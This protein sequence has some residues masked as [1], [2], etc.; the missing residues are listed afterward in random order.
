MGNHQFDGQI[1]F[2]LYALIAM[3]VINIAAN[4]IAMYKDKKIYK[5]DVDRQLERMY[6]Y[7]VKPL[8]STTRDRTGG[9]YWAE[10]EYGT[11]SDKQRSLLISDIKNDGFRDPYVEK[12]C[13][14]MHFCKDKIA[15][16]IL[17]KREE[18]L[19]IMIEKNEFD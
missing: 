1:R 14:G 10:L 2:V 4:D 19:R 13:D 11:L 8:S 16:E 9:D 15:V 6:E 18:R 12:N 7:S 5:G 17:V 3:M